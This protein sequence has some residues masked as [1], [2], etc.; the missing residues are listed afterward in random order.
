MGLLGDRPLGF[1]V[2]NAVRPANY[3]AVMR[4]LR[5]YP[6]PADAI[7]RYLFGRGAYP[8]DV[9]V[10]T[11]EGKIAIRLY[12]AHDMITVNEVFARR[13][14]ACP[15]ATRTVVDIGSNI[16]I[17]ALYFL[18]RGPAVRCILYEPDPR[19]V[20]RLRENLHGREDRYELHEAAVADRAGDLEFGVET[21]GRYGGL[22]AQTGETITVACRHINGVLEDVLAGTDVIDVLK[23][24]T[25][26]AE[27]ATLA[28]IRPDL[29][30]RVRR[31]VLEVEGGP[32]PE[33]PGFASSLS[34]DTARLDNRA[35][36]AE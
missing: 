13:D 30:S 32:V 5:C 16:G 4:G 27:R 25:E 33:R 24:D 11:P 10:R 19:N 8:H 21:F 35:L 17:S 15:P 3:A 28:A 20:A 36:A 23:I 26:G 9:A 29:L 31:V 12:S 1:V 14:Y 6:R 18:T 34:C 22:G 7:G 2:R